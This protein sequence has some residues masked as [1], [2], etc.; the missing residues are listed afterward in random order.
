VQGEAWGRAGV[1]GEASRAERA[2]GLVPARAAGTDN[3]DAKMQA[4]NTDP[5]QPTFKSL[6]FTPVPCLPGEFAI[7]GKP[8]KWAGIAAVPLHPEFGSDTSPQLMQLGWRAD[9]IYCRFAVKDPNRHLDKCS[10]RN[11]WQG[12]TVEVWIDCLNSKEKYRARHAGQQF[13]IW[14]DGSA[15]D[16]SLTGG[17]SVVEKRGGWYAPNALHQAELNRATTMT[18]DGYVMEFRV[19][20][21]RLVDADFAAG[22]IIGFN[23]YVSTMSGT[24]WYWSAGKQ[25]GTYGQPDTW[26]DLLLA[27]S[28][29]TI[30]LADKP[31]TPTGKPE[32]LLA[33]QPL[34]LKVTDGDMNL[35]PLRADKVM[36]TLKPAHGGQQIAVLEET[37]PSTGV[38]EGS[39]STALAV[40]DDQPGVLAV[41]EG[42]RVHAVYLD[43][44]RANGARNS[45]IS[46][47]LQF[48][49]AVVAQV[50]PR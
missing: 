23:S 42:E 2:A 7:D 49:G 43:Q 24:D 3:A 6:A 26:G 1:E 46:L 4:E 11:F 27:G 8:E 22:R 41:Y 35:S 21:E 14:P 45:E 33:G 12:D 30:E 37:G 5:Y 9:G 25:A 15:D 34:K 28:D 40:G 44:A 50:A 20:A 38:F 47:Q 32:L 36:V 48:A 31:A 16:P 17:E 39:V 10:I 18:P 19:P 13:W 29:A